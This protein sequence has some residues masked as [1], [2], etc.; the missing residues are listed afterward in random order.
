[1]KLIGTYF[2]PFTRRVGAALIVLDLPFRHEPLNGYTDPARA[3][4]LN[5]VGKVPVLEL[6]DGER[7]L[8]SGV[9]LDYLDERVGPRRALTPPA[10]EA[11]RA[12]LQLAA[13]AAT[14]YE[15]TTARHA[16]AQRPD[17]RVQ[18]ALIE[19]YRTQLLGG[20][21]ALEQAARTNGQIGAGALGIATLSAVVAFDYAHATHPDL[22]LPSRAPTLAAVVDALAQHPAF[23]DTRP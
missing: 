7:I 22:A 8:D 14:L 16:E 4:A 18:P 3:D 1:M 12:A 5:P 6:D 11:R 13:I 19:R 21:A 23:A 20:F 9:I 15:K 2:S 17:G 10:G